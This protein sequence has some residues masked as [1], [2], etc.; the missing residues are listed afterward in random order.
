VAGAYEDDFKDAKV[1]MQNSINNMVKWGGIIGCAVFLIIL[2]G[3]VVIS[4]KISN[5]IKL[6]TE[7]ADEISCGNLDRVIDVHTKDETG[8][9]AA[10][11]KRMQASLV[12]FMK[13][14]QKR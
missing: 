11:F 9:L 13:R 14:A 10:A 7:A 8:Q 2:L 1:K 6:L 3:A 12:A 5:A 4:E